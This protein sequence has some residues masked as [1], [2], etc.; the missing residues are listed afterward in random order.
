MNKTHVILASDD[1]VYFW[2]YRSNHSKAVTL[3]QQRKSKSGKE[4]A[5]HVEEIPKPDQIYDKETWRKP[6]IATQDT[7]SSIAAGP[8]SFIVGRMS[9]Q[10]LKFSLPYIGLENKLMLRCRPQQLQMNCDSTK[11]SIID[12][13]GILSFYDM[14]DTSEGNSG[15]GCHLPTERKEVWSLV[16]S[17]D[18]PSLC[19]LM[20]KN[21]LFVLKDFEPEEPILS[22]GYLCD[23]TDLEVK[24][25]ML[26]DILKDPEE[27]KNIKS[28]FV[29]YEAKSLRD[30]RE[31]ITT[32]SLKE[33][34]DFCEKNSHK[35]LWQLVTEAALDKLNFNIAERAFVKNEDYYGVQLISRLQNLDEKVKQKAEVACYF[36]RYDEAEQIFK[37]IDRKDL[38]LDLRMRLGDWAKVI[39]LIESG[40]GNDEMLKRAHKNL[41]D[42]SAERQKW[43]KAAKYFKLAHD[44]E[45]LA[46]A[47]YKLEDFTSLEKLLDSIPENAPILEILGNKFQSM[48]LC[49]AAV[50]AFVKF[51]DVKKA[52]DCCVLLNEWNLAV[53]LAEQHNFVQIEQLLQKYAAHL[54]EK[55]KKMEAIELYRKANK[56]TDAARLLA[57]MAQ[58]L[59]EKN[60]PL[61]LIKKI[62]VLAAFEVDSYKQRVFDAQ[63]AQI[64][65][66][67]QTAADVA[68]KTMN[69]LITSDIS[70]SAD[71]ALT[72]P[73]KG[74]EGI[75]FFLLCQRQLYQK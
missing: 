33:A 64:T 43:A 52:I 72:N 51:G 35:R 62:Y 67:G 11:F 48:G 44:F 37:D 5:F 59:R 3:E 70:T 29:D 57:E 14:N 53:D 47:Y 6:E 20:E 38:A 61:L 50:N 46:N 34:C 41:G 21:R 63:V 4:N 19:A 68:A 23:F 74:A 36:K 16:W 28:M 1:V 12:I 26:D 13:N 40:A 15:N 73:W 66:T 7:I 18:N 9:G 42:Y 71:K 55:N 31:M 27:I 39:Q 30:C 58:E 32:V 10:V 22:A 45:S 60:A 8:D 2:Q 54:I 24:S 25:V 69:S 17:T 56:N 49:S 75:H 65:G